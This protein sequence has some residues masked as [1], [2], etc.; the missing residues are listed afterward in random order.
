MGTSWSS[1]SY[2]DQCMPYIGRR[3]K[4]T[5]IFN[6]NISKQLEVRK[7]QLNSKFI[8][9]KDEGLFTKTYIPKGTIVLNANDPLCLKMN[10]VMINLEGVIDAKTSKDL[11]N[12]LIDLESNYYNVQKASLN[13]NMR[14]LGAPTGVYYETIQDI[15][16]NTELTRMYGYTT[17]TLELFDILTTHNI[18]GFVKYI[19]ELKNRTH[20]DLYATKILLLDSC[21]D[22]YD[23]TLSVDAFDSQTTG[24]ELKNIGN[25]VKNYYHIYT[26]LKTVF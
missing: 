21:F 10:D 22:N 6:E 12:A 7:S 18:Y 4:E 23:K 14:M 17:W 1:S 9:G 15:P 26:M 25:E 5:V 20:N 2:I 8:E 19:H 3:S 13:V 11:Y 16:P 24:L